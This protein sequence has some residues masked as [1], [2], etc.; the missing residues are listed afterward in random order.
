MIEAEQALEDAL[1]IDAEIS[2]AERYSDKP[3][4]ALDSRQREQLAAKYENRW[5]DFVRRFGVATYGSM[6][7]RQMALMEGVTLKR[8]WLRSQVA[9]VPKDVFEELLESFLEELP[10]H[11]LSTGNL[12]TKIVDVWRGQTGEAPI[13]GD[14]PTH[15]CPNCG[16]RW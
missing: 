4:V 13:R 6:T 7:M 15:K 9:R 11:Q 2:E 14:G 5:L 8:V 12:L 16:H 3:L 10:D 1:K